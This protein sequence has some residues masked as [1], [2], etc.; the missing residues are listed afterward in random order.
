MKRKYFTMVLVLLLVVQLL[1]VNYVWASDGDDIGAKGWVTVYSTEGE[2]FNGEYLAS[3]IKITEPDGTTPIEPDANGDY[4]D[5][6]AGAKIELLYAFSLSDGVEP[7][8]NEYKEGDFFCITLPGGLNITPIGGT[9]EA[10]GPDGT[11]I[12]ADW[13]ILGNELEVVLTEEGAAIKQTGRWGRVS[14]SGVF[15]PLEAGD[16]TVTKVYFGSQTIVIN[17]QPLPLASSLLKSGSYNAESNEITWTISI[18]PPAGNPGLSYRGYTVVDAYSDNQ[19]YV[20]GSFSVR[21]GTEAA[22]EVSDDDLVIKPEENT[23]EYTF[24]GDTG[25]VQ[26][27][28]YRTKPNTFA[29]ANGESVF[30]NTVDLH[31]NQEQAAEPVTG[32]VSLDW[33]DKTGGVTAN[34][35]DDPDVVKWTITVNPGETGA[36]LSGA[37]IIDELHEHLELIANS[38]HPVQVQFGQQGAI[39]VDPGGGPGQ[40]DYTDDT[41]TY[42]FPAANQPVA[43][44]NVRLIFYTRVKDEHRDEV[45]DDN[46]AINFS[47]TA[48]LVWDESL[49]LDKFPS[50]SYTTGSGQGDGVHDGGLLAKSAENSGERYIYLDKDIIK[51]T[52]VVNRNQVSMTNA[53]V[54]DK[55]PAGQVL[56]IDGED[57]PFTVSGTGFIDVIVAKSD[58]ANFSYTAAGMGSLES[59][60]YSLPTPTDI[61]YTITYFT[62]ISDWTA[63]YQNGTVAYRNNVAL[64]R[65]GGREEILGAKD[66]ASQL[67]NKIVAKDYDYTTHLVQWQVVVNR[68]LLPLNNAIVTDNLPSGMVLFI[69]GEHLFEVTATGSGDAVVNAEDGGT[70]FTVTLPSPTSDQYT[71]KFWT[72][73]TEEALAEKWDNQR[74]FTNEVLLEADEIGSPIRHTVSARI[75]NPVLSKSGWQGDDT[76]GNSDTL[77]WSV[78]LN[79]A[80]STLSNAVARDQLHAALALEPDSVKLY[81]IEVNPS[82]GVGIESTKALVTE[83]YT[84]VLPTVDNDNTLEVYLPDGN[85]A[86]LL[87]FSTLILDSRVGTIENSVELV[88]ENTTPAGS[89]ESGMISVK[90]YCS[91]GGSGSNSLTVRKTDSSDNPLAGSVFRLVNVNR[92]PITRNGNEVR[93]TTNASGEALFI[94][95]PGWV[96]FA[97]EIE[98]AP[99]YLLAAEPFYFGSRLAGDEEVIVRNA[100]ALADV[101]IT[102]R[103]AGGV[104]LAGGLFT[105]TGRDYKNDEVS[106]NATAVGG[107]VTFTNVTLNMAGQPYTLREIEAPIGHMVSLDSLA[108]TVEYNGTKTGLVV[109]ISP[110]GGLNNIPVET[111]VWFTKTG[112]AGKLLA[113][114]SFRIDGADYLGR[115]ISQ[116]AA[117]DEDGVV[118]FSGIQVGNYT[119]S[120]V[121]PPIGYLQPV[122]AEIL[123][124]EV[125]YNADK[126]DLIATIWDIVPGSSAVTAYANTKALTSISFQKVSASGAPLRGGRFELSGVD[127]AGEPVLLTATSVEGVVT[128]TDVP[129]DDGNGYVVKELTPPSGYHRTAIELFATVRY[130]NGKKEVITSISDET[131]TNIEIAYAEIIVIKSDEDGKRLAGAEFT[132]YNS[133]GE[134]VA[135]AVS[136]QDGIANFGQTIEGNYTIRETKAPKGYLV[137][138]EEIRLAINDFYSQTFTVVNEKDPDPKEEDKE[139][140]PKTGSA[141]PRGYMVVASFSLL[142]LGAV[143]TAKRKKLFDQ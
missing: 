37:K 13:S 141:N 77:Y 67:L 89:G 88:G 56:L 11:Y 49:D 27:I 142:L 63:L 66:F 3:S 19:D 129:V 83:G 60:S 26:T 143:L 58:T 73:L 107:T 44:T 62:Q 78:Y 41:L 1:T 94:G 65:Q 7:D 102:K 55:I 21:S 109:S 136:D 23:I 74:N 124:V 28:T 123:R 114:G 51:W 82:T 103:G 2:E 9:I 53:V 130:S 80:Q 20:S 91:T 113:G 120:E 54:E 76:I 34:A 16:D 106:W 96:F 8:I 72:L 59:F 40:Y 125:A 85:L 117:A 110:S 97:E 70:A 52:I 84:V 46:N 25:G 139:G 93:S 86:Y 90:D 128:F 42:H 104:P 71:I 12:L 87:E 48:T 64:I 15:K 98:P 36:S 35:T 111:D 50:A 133:I 18:T 32:R 14:L 39:D 30:D 135:T 95:L 33:L 105:L 116:M 108:V 17:R 75:R 29:G 137:N 101:T 81:T 127:C 92:Q 138:P 134:P 4:H 132:L 122:E 22:I 57:H 10:D 24:P 43:G 118:V 99:G 69:D 31:R 119:I 140:L 5:V 121:D 38:E 79:L 61:T 68:N 100:R 112:L 45:L 47:N 6:P 126:T 115:P 131:L